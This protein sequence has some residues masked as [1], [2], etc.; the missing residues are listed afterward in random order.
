MPESERSV[1]ILSA[2]IALAI[3]QDKNSLEVN[4]LGNF[5][6]AIGCELLLLAAQLECEEDAV[7]MAATSEKQGKL[8]ELEDR[9]RKL[10]DQFVRLTS[11]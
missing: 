5:I 7:E 6:T 9:L 4:W 1:A 8:Q 10:E 3:A 11:G 2:A